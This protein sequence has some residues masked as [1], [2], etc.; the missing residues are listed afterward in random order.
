MEFRI[1][2]IKISLPKSELPSQKKEKNY[3][4]L[5]RTLIQDYP[6]IY[7]NYITFQK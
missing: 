4:K 5:Y 7:I 3:D 1:N 6:N 2:F